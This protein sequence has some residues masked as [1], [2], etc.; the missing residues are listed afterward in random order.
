[1][2]ALDSRAYED[3]VLK[4]L[5]KRLPHLPD[6]LLT[7]YAVDLSMSRIELR[8][9]T[10]GVVRLWNKAAM[11]A[12]PT[13]LVCQQLL[14][15]HEELKR[16]NDVDLT[17]PQWWQNREQARHQQLGSDISDL[18]ALLTASHGGLGVITQNQLRAAGAA[19][20]TLGDAEIDQACAAAG[21]QV[22]EPVELPTTAG[23]RGRFETLDT[24]LIGAGVDSVA[25]LVYPQMTGFGLLG[26]FSVTPPPPQ[27]GKA[28]LT[29]RAL[30]QRRQELERL[31]DSPAVRAAK[32]AVGILLTEADA[33]T[34]LAT[35]ALF[36][37]LR[38]VR[39][40][41]A[42]GAQARTLFS[43]LTRTRLDPA[44]AGRVAV[45]VLAEG[46]VKRDPLAAVT[47]LL[48][49]GELVAAQQLAA[50]LPGP[51]GD[52]AREA[53]RR[54]REQVDALRQAAAEDLG[55]GRD[56]QAA[57]RLRDALRQA[58]D[59]PGL[60]EELA[61][62]PAAPVLGVTAHPD[63]GG[64]RIA[65]RPAAGHDDSTAFR[66]VRGEGRPPVDPDDGRELVVG[67]GHSTT[68]DAPPVGQRLHYAVFAR[69][70]G[71]RWSRSASTDVQVVPPVTDVVV[72]GG[73]KVVT[74]RW[75]AHPDVARVEVT[76]MAAGP[77]GRDEPVTVER[78]QLFRDS[79]AAD[80]VQYFYTLV[81]CYPPTGGGPALRSEP[82]VVRGAT[83]L[84][85]RPVASL[86]A[87]PISGASLAVR[88]SWRQKTGSEIVVRRTPE[89]CPWEYG[90][91]VPRTEL[92]RWGVELDGSLSA[93]GEAIT[94]V[95]P[96][97]PGRSFYVPFTLDLDGGGVRGQDAVV[98]HIE[99]V[100]RVRAQRF[101]DDI[102]VTWLWPHEVS[103]AEVGWAGGGR[104]ITLAQYRDEGGCQ[105]R[106]VPEVT[107]VQVG[108]VIL[109]EHNDENC[110]AP[111]SVEV[112][113]RPPQ[114]AYQVRR[115]GLALLGGVRCTVTLSST[116]AIP[117][118]TVIL[119][120]AVGQAMPLSPDAGI[121]LL[122]APVVI[123]PGVPLT[124][125]E[126]T[127]PRLRKPYWLRCFLAPP[128]CAL[129]V[130]PP[131]SQLK[132]S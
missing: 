10:D 104:R 77:G 6:D 74:G 50:T 90:H 31:P 44:D 49:E 53:V 32:E 105:L 96:V 67:T 72:K 9:R 37:L 42:D 118:A 54:Q 58:S 16:S 86:T 27:G 65:W 21:L 108:A 8:E 76:R 124:L 47:E 66:V 56:E 51:A 40:K 14:R 71:G 23:M 125:P 68:D 2:A 78:H 18:A 111:I 120:A 98:D 64:V 4:P 46:S 130:D 119:V 93:K 100:R 19:H 112:D 85:A 20:G 38:A 22:V 132:V 97:P 39:E 55:A 15:E 106:D 35:L 101:G 88:L 70:P 129:L 45:S 48:V 30:E 7:R 89:P 61:K 107:R 126:A 13:G 24:K 87:V 34:D 84:E 57:A 103:A 43:L 41:R 11:K 122:R 131:V 102:R 99:P 110:S 80:G 82:V 28:T 95:A 17:D 29:R 59:L 123:E 117:G 81:A 128:A 60:A 26:G 69:T 1:M 79:S 114:L 91:L 12:G 52:T 36:Q 113:E 115:S 3:T 127:V 92:D 73:D 83:R 5:R 121:E 63:G 25:G 116:A 94:L 33:G 109:D 75:R 62:V